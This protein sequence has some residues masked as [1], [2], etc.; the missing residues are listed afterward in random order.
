MF[1]MGLLCATLSAY[2]ANPVLGEVELIAASKAER[3]AGVWVDGQYVGYVRNIRGGG[4]LVLVPG[5]HQLEFKLIGHQDVKSTIVVEPG[6]QAQYRVT[7]PQNPDLTYPNKAETARLRVSVTPTEAAVFVN[8][9]FVGHVDRFDGANGMRLKAGT[10][11]FTI[12]LPG[13]QAFETEMTLVAGQNYEIKTNL[14]QASIE[15]QASELTAGDAIDA[16][17]R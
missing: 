6:K 11:R 14:P 5:E 1:F 7:M 16:L 9:A 2:A 3:D 17:A 8:D 12:A 13:Y 10:Y 15:D 4:K